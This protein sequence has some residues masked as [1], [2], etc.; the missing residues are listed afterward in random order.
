MCAT[1][2]FLLLQSVFGVFFRGR[3]QADRDGDV[4]ETRSMVCV[5][6][7]HIVGSMHDKTFRNILTIKSIKSTVPFTGCH[8]EI[9][10][11]TPHNGDAMA[12][13]MNV[14]ADVG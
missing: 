13:T 12:M 14:A 3:A 6:F 2:L 8:Y 5:L 9:L 7:Y 4:K 1:V 11:C 10:Q